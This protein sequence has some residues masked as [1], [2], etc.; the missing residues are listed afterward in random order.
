MP[1]WS[2][3]GNQVA[4]MRDNNIFLVKLLYDNSESQVTTDGKFNEIINGVPDWVY[5]EEF[6]FNSALTFNADGTMLCWLKFNESKV[7]EYSLQLYK[8]MKPEKREFELYPGYY[9]YKYPKAGEDNSKVTAWSYDIK[10]HKTQQLQVP[11]DEDGYMPRILPTENPEKILVYT[12][13]RHQ[14][15]LNL[16]T[17]NPRSTLSQLL[18]KESVAKYVKE[19]AMEAIRIG[20]D[21]I[22]MPSDRDGY[23]HLYLY[24]QNGKLLRKIGDGKYDIT[25]VYGYD[26]KTGDVYYQAAP[27]NPH[28]RQIMVTRKNGK[29]VRL[30]NQE[31]WNE[32]I[33]SGDCKYF[34]NTWSDINNPYVYTTRNNQGKVIATNLDNKELQAKT[35]QYGWTKNEMLS[36]IHI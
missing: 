21:Y 17:V 30:T 12:M 22:L 35:R 13:N 36:L 31:G 9:S 16:Y 7:K 26:E 20:K 15:V 27:L 1:V 6:A 28:D 8:G 24:S 10:S 34:V 19:E 29:T 14:D 33:F 5:E 11:M 2:P 25:K 23:M 32:A 3:D 18:I 4:F